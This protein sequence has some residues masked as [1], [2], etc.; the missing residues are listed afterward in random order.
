MIN[1]STSHLLGKDDV[2]VVTT[3]DG[4]DTLFSKA[5]QSTYHSTFGAVSESKHT[6][7][8]NGL[9]T[10]LHRSK[11]RILEFG[12]GT[13]LNAFLAFLFSQKHALQID[14]TGFEEYPIDMS[15]ICS[16]DYPGYLVCSEKANA[17]HQM[18]ELKTFRTDYF[19]FQRSDQWDILHLDG[20]FDCI[21]FDAF[22]PAAQPEL[23]DQETFDQLFKISSEGGCLVTYCSKGEVRRRMIKAGYN[24]KRIPGAPGKREMLQAFRTI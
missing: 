21:F 12:F 14:Y 20:Q 10:Q 8:Q 3:S 15:I 18:H 7:L 24:T 11:I 2:F 19:K 4:S 17:F 9:K 6:F 16:L 23:W 5:Y 22:D 1:K 13:G